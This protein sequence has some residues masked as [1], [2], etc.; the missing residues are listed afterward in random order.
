MVLLFCIFHHQVATAAG[1]N[2]TTEYC[3]IVW[4]SYNCYRCHFPEGRNFLRF[5]AKSP[6]PTVNSHVGRRNGLRLT[7]DLHS[8]TV[9][10]GTLEKEYEAFSIFIGQPQEFPMMMEKSLQLQPGFEHFID[11]S[12]RVV[13]TKDIQ[14]IPPEERDCFYH[15]E[16]NLEFYEG[17]TFSNCRLECAI[18]KSEQIYNCT[19]WHLPRVGI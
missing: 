13:T 7:L 2:I 16:S 11:L 4:L 5:F 18:K 14:N 3:H 15:N 6:H 8:N 19:P 9:S 10:F 1:L 17:Y 12:A